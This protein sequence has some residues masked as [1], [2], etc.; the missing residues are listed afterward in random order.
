MCRGC[1]NGCPNEGMI[2]DTRKKIISDIRIRTRN[3]PSTSPPSATLPR[4]SPSFRSDQQG[5]STL[6]D[7]LNVLRTTLKIA[8]LAS[9]TVTADVSAVVPLDY[10][11][12]PPQ[13]LEIPPSCPVCGRN[14]KC[15]CPLSAHLLF[16]WSS[17]FFLVDTCF[18]C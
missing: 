13:N 12:F 11:T 2:S 18:F 3:P 14:V 5:P 10:E 8:T 16:L 15:L 7:I 9:C 6:E 1:P 17:L 4:N